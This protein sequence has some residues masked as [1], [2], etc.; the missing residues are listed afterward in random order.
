ML[1]NRLWQQ[2]Y[3]VTARSKLGF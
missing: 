3:S 2:I 1:I